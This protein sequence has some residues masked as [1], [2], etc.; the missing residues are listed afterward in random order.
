MKQKN[1][2]KKTEDEKPEE[3]EKINDDELPSL[4]HLDLEDA[5]KKVLDVPW[6]ESVEDS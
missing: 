3:T 1:S 2:T 6:K 5:L 4:S